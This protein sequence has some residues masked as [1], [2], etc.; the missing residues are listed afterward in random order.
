[1]RRIRE[2]A[3]LFF[4]ARRLVESSTASTHH[5]E[6]TRAPPACGQIVLQSAAATR[7]E[8]HPT[9]APVDPARKPHVKRAT[10]RSVA[11][12]RSL[13]R[14]F[15]DPRSRGGFGRRYPRHPRHQGRRFDRPANT[16][17]TSIAPAPPSPRVPRHPPA[18]ASKQ[19]LG[20][21]NP[22]M[23]SR[24]PGSH[25]RGAARRGRHQCMG[26]CARTSGGGD[27]GGASIQLFFPIDRVATYLSA[28]A[29]AEPP[30]SLPLGMDAAKSRA[31]RGAIPS[32]RR[33]LPRHPDI[34]SKCC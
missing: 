11:G 33:K 8:R 29:D 25:A 32:C 18:P 28:Y 12:L 6:S 15:S 34:T 16:S 1:M 27:L 20:R 4:S 3:C 23:D 24:I 22:E 17:R 26:E 5:R 13:N 7:R 9:L 21:S 10:A 2:L 31:I 19:K 14:S 30:L